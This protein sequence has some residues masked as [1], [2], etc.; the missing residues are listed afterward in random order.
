MC[1]MLDRV[2]SC[3][4]FCM[5]VGSESQRPLCVEGRLCSIT[6]KVPLSPLHP[7]HMQTASHH[8]LSLTHTCWGHTY[9]QTGCGKHPHSGGP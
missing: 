7:A 9:S 5:A 2:C 6:E 3:G 4:L 8:T 1:S